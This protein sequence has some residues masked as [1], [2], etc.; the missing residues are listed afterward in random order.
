MLNLDFIL[1]QET[2]NIRHPAK[3][4]RKRRF[5]TDNTPFLPA[6]RQFCHFFRAVI[7]PDF[8][9]SH[10]DYLFARV[11]YSLTKRET[12]NDILPQMVNEKLICFAL[13]ANSQKKKSLERFCLLYGENFS[14]EVT[15]VN[16]SSIKRKPVAETQCEVIYRLSPRIVSPA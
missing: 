8:N 10:Y 6:R 1:Y 12:Q 2:T 14:P 4:S 11:N 15:P 7:S 3:G 13:S 16:T 5:F 9:L